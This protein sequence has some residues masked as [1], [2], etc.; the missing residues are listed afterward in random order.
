[1]P[2]EGWTRL[3]WHDLA[4]RLGLDLDDSIYPTTLQFP[5]SSWPVSIQPPAEGSLD[6]EQFARL[7]AHLSAVS[8][9]GASSEC[10]SFYTPLLS[11]DMVTPVVYVSTLSEVPD[12]YELDLD[13]FDV[14]GSPTNLWPS[15][16]SWL[17]YTDWDLCGTRVSGSEALIGR[18]L[19][20]EALET[21]S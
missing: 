1:M 14:S 17:V 21:R 15:D 9:D 11:E 16:R 3:S 10:F 8:R 2:G 12:L 7:V 5:Y 13:E 20:D 4:R 18:L 6:R 19:E